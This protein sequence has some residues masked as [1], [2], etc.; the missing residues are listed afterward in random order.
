M[1]YQHINHHQFFRDSDKNDMVVYTTWHEDEILTIHFYDITLEKT[2]VRVEGVAYIYH[3]SHPTDYFSESAEHQCIFEKYGCNIDFVA[4]RHRTEAVEINLEKDIDQKVTK[5]K[6]F[7]HKFCDEQW[8]MRD[9]SKQGKQGF[10]AWHG[11]TSKMIMVEV[12]SPTELKLIE[13][14]EEVTGEHWF[15]QAD[16]IKWTFEDKTFDTQPRY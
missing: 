1:K 11:P 14:K 2:I 16:L 9:W 12:E 10:A 13:T 3:M 8:E 4:A 7:K 6:T 15:W 5:N